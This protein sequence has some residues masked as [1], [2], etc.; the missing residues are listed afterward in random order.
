M[1]AVRRST[2]RPFCD[3]YLLEYSGEHVRYEFDMFIW[4]GAICGNSSVQVGA[5]TQ[6]DALRLKNVLIEAFAVH[7]RNVIDFLYIDSPQ[8]TDVIA[9]DFLNPGE[10]SRLRPAMSPHLSRARVRANK[11]IAHLTTERLAGSPPEKAWDFSAMLSDVAP[12]LRLF[13]ESALPSRLAPGLA[14]DVAAMWPQ[15]ANGLQVGG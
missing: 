4:L 5:P 15:P 9:A 8:A 7:L 6:P 2:V 3:A 12:L 11:E 13:I 1:G 10:W 14:Q